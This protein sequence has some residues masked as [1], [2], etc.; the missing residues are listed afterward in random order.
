MKKQ[1]QCRAVLN[2]THLFWKEASADYNP[3]VTKK[4]S[5]L[6]PVVEDGGWGEVSGMKDLTLEAK[7]TSQGWPGIKNGG[8]VLDCLQRAL[9]L[10][11]ACMDSLLNVQLFTEILNVYIYY[12]KIGIEEVIVFDCEDDMITQH[13]ARSPLIS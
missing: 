6:P 10:A 7:Q 1:D 5:N 13:L 11:D 2:C 9:K 3:P 12:Y 4:P 8:K